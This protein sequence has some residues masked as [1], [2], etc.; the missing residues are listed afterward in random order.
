MIGVVRVLCDE[1]VVVR[2][3]AGSMLACFTSTEDFWEFAATWVARALCRELVVDRVATGNV[4]IGFTS[5]GDF[6][7]GLGGLEAGAG[8]GDLRKVLPCHGVKLL[9]DQVFP[10]LEG[11]LMAGD[12]WLT[13]FPRTED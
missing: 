5:T 10:E 1:L 12:G 3:A 7:E 8:D 11:G 6:W 4:L 9:P 13:A 2:V